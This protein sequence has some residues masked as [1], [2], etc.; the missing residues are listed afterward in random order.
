MLVELT[1]GLLATGHY[2]EP[3]EEGDEI[4]IKVDH[5][6]G[7]R[8]QAVIDAESV[9]EEIEK[10]ANGE[11]LAKEY[12]ATI[13]EAREGSSIKG[14]PKI[15]FNLQSDQGQ[16]L[17]Y[18]LIVNGEPSPRVDM[19]LAAVFPEIELQNGGNITL[20]PAMFVGLRVKIEEHWNVGIRWFPIP[21]SL[22]GDLEIEQ[23]KEAI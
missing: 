12:F 16:Y 23:R 1:A 9:L 20:D 6:L 14:E 10:T 11:Y 19:V 5:Y 15:T 17:T 7:I 4:Y 18:D 21:A 2:T 22:F 13:V 8:S 3:D